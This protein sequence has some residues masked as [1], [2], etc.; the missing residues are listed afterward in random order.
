MIYE[1]DDISGS[2]DDSGSSAG[3]QSEDS[4]TDSYAGTDS[5]FLGDSEV[6]DESSL[7]E[8]WCPPV[9]GGGDGIGTGDV[10]SELMDDDLPELFAPPPPTGSRRSD[11]SGSQSATHSDSDDSAHAE[12]GVAIPRFRAGWNYFEFLQGYIV[13]NSPTTMFSAHCNNPAHGRCHF[14]LSASE[15]NHSRRLGQG[16]PLGAL[17]FWLAL[18]DTGSREHHQAIKVLVCS[19]RSFNERRRWRQILREVP[20]SYV[21]FDALERLKRDD[22]DSEPDE[23][24]YFRTQF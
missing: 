14:D 17:A 7:D 10:I 23:L 12:A 16:R 22:T 13:W 8:V 1:E 20:G 19:S 5:S 3:E 2:S 24:P 4:K 6:S 11:G 15:S 21:L 9:G 18:S